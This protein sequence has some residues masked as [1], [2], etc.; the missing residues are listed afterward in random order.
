[1]KP[2]ENGVAFPARDEIQPD[3]GG[4]LVDYSP[5]LNPV[6]EGPVK[7]RRSDSDDSWAVKVLPRDAV[8][9]LM[10]AF[11]GIDGL[12]KSAQRLLVAEAATVLDAARRAPRE[13]Q[14]EQ[15]LAFGEERLGK[16]ARA[17]KRTGGR[18]GSQVV[19]RHLHRQ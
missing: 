13:E 18:I 4:A 5:Q 10:V 17:L 14:R 8:E 7:F 1:M 11:D 6:A 12:T 19:R 9:N 2:F 15:H 16:L 3:S